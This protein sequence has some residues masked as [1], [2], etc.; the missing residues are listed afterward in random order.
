MC[1]SPKK[2]SGMLFVWTG[3]YKVSHPCVCPTLLVLCYLWTNDMEGLLSMDARDLQRLHPWDVAQQSAGLKAHKC[4]DMHKHYSYKSKTLSGFSLCCSPPPAAPCA[5]WVCGHNQ[6]LPQ[7]FP[8]LLWPSEPGAQRDQSA[9]SAAHWPAP[10]LPCGADRAAQNMKWEHK[11]W[12]EE[13][14][15]YSVK[16]LVTHTHTHRKREKKAVTWSRWIRMTGLFVHLQHWI[17]VYSCQ[18]SHL[19]S[20]LTETLTGLQNSQLHFFRHVFGFEW[21]LLMSHRTE[22]MS[23]F[24]TQRR[25]KYC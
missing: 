18:M 23:H 1:M 8:H 25:Q 16:K 5:R 12:R 9:A 17:P 24:Q 22:R 4:R 7:H 21:L 14:L 13:K 3:L 10:L 11:I 2:A 20:E 19:T 15:W 6:P